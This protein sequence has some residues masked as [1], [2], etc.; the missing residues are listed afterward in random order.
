MNWS[1]KRRNLDYQFPNQRVEV[2]VAK[3]E[4]GKVAGVFKPV[5]IPLFPVEPPPE[6]AWTELRYEAYCF[7][8]PAL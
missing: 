1:W 5:R 6:L 2:F 8:V 3:A 7:V 4:D